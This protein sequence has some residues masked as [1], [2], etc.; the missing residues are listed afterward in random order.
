[1]IHQANSVKAQ[2]QK[3]NSCFLEIELKY[4]YFAWDSVSPECKGLISFS[5]DLGSSSLFI[6][7]FWRERG[8]DLKKTNRNPPQLVLD[9][10]GETKHRTHNQLFVPTVCVCFFFFYSC[11]AAF[12]SSDLH[13]VDLYQRQHN[14]HHFINLYTWMTELKSQWVQLKWKQSNDR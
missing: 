5:H 14:K 10:T 12:P 3:I 13:Q 11:C 1:M 4:R 9:H 8:S 6:F 2:E 7:K